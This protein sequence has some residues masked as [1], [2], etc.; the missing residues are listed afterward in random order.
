MD[1]TH[2]NNAIEKQA[3]EDHPVLWRS[4]QGKQV[5]MRV[6]MHLLSVN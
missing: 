5:T 6:Y 1:N 3:Y 4:L 2:S